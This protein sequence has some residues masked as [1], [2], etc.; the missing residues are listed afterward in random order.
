MSR[1]SVKDY[2]VLRDR[3]VRRLL[4]V[5]NCKLPRVIPVAC[6]GKLLTTYDYCVEILTSTVLE[7]M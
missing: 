3:R 2:G 5:A 1:A 6:R 7:K 4:T